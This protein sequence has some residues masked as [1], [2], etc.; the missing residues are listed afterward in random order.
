MDFNGFNEFCRDPINHNFIIN[1]INESFIAGATYS[2]GREIEMSIRFTSGKSYAEDRIEF[3]SRSEH[4]VSVREFV[5]SPKTRHLAF[6]MF[7][8]AFFDGCRFVGG[9]GDVLELAKEYAERVLGKIFPLPD[10]NKF[11][12]FFVD[13]IKKSN[14]NPKLF[15][16]V[17][18]GI[19]ESEDP[20][21]NYVKD[22]AKK[23][24]DRLIDQE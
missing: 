21:F 12:D 5:S 22:F 11:V 13:E 8:N 1:S 9:E 4:P 10:L 16:D 7:T 3:Y 15:V 24:K 17:M 20:S 14:K 18:N 2:K 6:D 19:L 23:M